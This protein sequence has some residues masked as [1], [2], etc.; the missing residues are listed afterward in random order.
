[1]SY[2]ALFSSLIMIDPVIIHPGSDQKYTIAL[3]RGALNRRDGW[4]SREEAL[5]S[6]RSNPFFAS[7][8]PE[9]LNVYCKRGL[10]E[11]PTGEL[12]LKTPGVQ[13]AIVYLDTRTSNEVF[14]RLI[15]LDKRIEIRWVMPDGSGSYEVGGAGHAPILCSRRLKNSS[16][17]KIPHT[18]HLIPQEAPSAL[19][20]EVGDFLKRNYGQNLTLKGRL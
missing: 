12:K 13:E 7:W 19:A 15:D 2:P 14:Q 4:T 9:V 10:Y 11:S 1:L 6:F 17:I 8:D 5:K 20:S 16:N 18:T 3:I